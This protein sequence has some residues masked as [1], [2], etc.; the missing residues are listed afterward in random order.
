MLVIGSSIYSLCVCDLASGMLVRIKGKR[1]TKQ[2]QVLPFINS[3]LYR[4]DR[5]VSVGGSG[6]ESVELLLK[7][8]ATFCH[9]RP[10]ELDSRP[11]TELNP[12][13]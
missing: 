3:S 5:L 12:K 9:V 8:C 7:V 11:P 4:S 6:Y 13:T 2:K 10:T 1:Y